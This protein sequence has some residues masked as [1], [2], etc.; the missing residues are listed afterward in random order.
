MLL[1]AA[2]VK[3][4]LKDMLRVL[5]DIGFVVCVCV[6]R[7]HVLLGPDT[8]QTGSLYCLVI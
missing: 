5:L 7:M 3:R 2:E 8:L 1:V 4:L 6:V